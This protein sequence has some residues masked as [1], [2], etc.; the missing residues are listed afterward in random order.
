MAIVY[1]YVRDFFIFIG[2]IIVGIFS[3]LWSLIQVL[4]KCVT[5]LTSLIAHAPLVLAVPLG[6]IIVIAVL[7]K[8][9]GREKGAG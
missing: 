1:Y 9:L 4:I 5:F 3:L 6:A 8:I 2:Q 7:Y